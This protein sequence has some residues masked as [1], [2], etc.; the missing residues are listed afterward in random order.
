LRAGVALEWSVIVAMVR[1]CQQLDL[2]GRSHCLCL[3]VR[4][5]NARRPEPP[6]KI[7]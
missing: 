7:T 6:L 2:P 3:H 5:R 1:P 4:R